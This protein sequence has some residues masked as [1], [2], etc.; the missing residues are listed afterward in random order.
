MKTNL[1]FTGI[2]IILMCACSKDNGEYP[3]AFAFHHSVI[4]AEGGFVI[5]D[6]E[7][8]VEISSRAGNL[9]TLRSLMALNLFDFF[10]EQGGGIFI[11]SFQLLSKDSV[12]INVWFDFETGS[13]TLPARTDDPDGIL[14]DPVYL[15]GGLVRYNSSTGEI[16]VC[17]GMG[18]GILNRGGNVFVDI[19]AHYCDSTNVLRELNHLLATVDFLNNDTLGVYM[20]SNIYK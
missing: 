12:R 2:G 11:E 17:L 4:E 7:T 8:Y 15:D 6:N 3:K 16:N 10:K 13:V 1:I 5:G 9:D 20:T 14:I 19:N 18:L